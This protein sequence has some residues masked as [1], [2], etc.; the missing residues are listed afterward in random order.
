ME[1]GAISQRL[2]IVL[3]VAPTVECEGTGHASLDTYKA[4]KLRIRTVTRNQNL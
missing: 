1:L 4:K 3:S 2:C